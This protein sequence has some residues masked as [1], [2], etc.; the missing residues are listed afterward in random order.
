MKKRKVIIDE[1]TGHQYKKEKAELRKILK[2]HISEEILKW[3]ETFQLSF[4]KEIFRLWEIP[5]I[6]E[7]VSRNSWLIGKLTNEL[8]YKNMPEGYF[9]LKKYFVIEKWKAKKGNYEY[10]FNQSLTPEVGKEALKKV[11]YMV[12][13]LASVSET[14][15]EFLQL[16][17]KKYQSHKV[18]MADKKTQETEFDKMLRAAINT[19]PLTLKNLRGQ[20]KKSREKK[21]EF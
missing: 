17:E 9:L 16:I 15:T 6:A 19:P 12:E 5:F 11:I 1:T 20:L 2:K 21:K 13:A 10:S 18:D 7:N 8:V 4:Y 14:R 3:Q